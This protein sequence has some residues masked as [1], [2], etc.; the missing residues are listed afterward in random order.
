MIG[1]VV[2]GVRAGEDAKER[3]FNGNDPDYQALFALPELIAELKRMYA[4]EDELGQLLGWIYEIAV[5]AGVEPGEMDE[6]L[7]R[8]CGAINSV[9]IV[10]YSEKIRDSGEKLLTVIAFFVSTFGALLLYVLVEYGVL[11]P[12]QQWSRFFEKADKVFDAMLE[13]YAHEEE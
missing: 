10:P 1:T 12:Y 7:D 4:R 11:R 2:R 9:M 5:V 13:H 6:R 8:V 3:A